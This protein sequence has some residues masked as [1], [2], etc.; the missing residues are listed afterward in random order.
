MAHVAS[1]RA[2]AHDT[3]PSMLLGGRLLSGGED[4]GREAA[5]VDASRIKSRRKVFE[6]KSR[7]RVVSKYDVRRLCINAGPTLRREAIARR[8]ASGQGTNVKEGPGLLLP[9]RN[10]RRNSSVHD[11]YVVRGKFQAKR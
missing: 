8:P 2:D 9:E 1:V 10:S 5:A 11:T 4:E 6:L 7:L 3:L